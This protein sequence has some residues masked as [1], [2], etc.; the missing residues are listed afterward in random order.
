MGL[1]LHGCFFVFSLR[2]ALTLRRHS[3]T[4]TD[5]AATST[6]AS[7]I[8]Q[9]TVVN[10]V[11]GNTRQQTPLE[12]VLVRNSWRLLTFPQ[13]QG[14]WTLAHSLFGE[15]LAPRRKNVQVFLC[16]P[17]ATWNDVGLHL[18]WRWRCACGAL[19]VRCGAVCLRCAVLRCVALCCLM[20]CRL[21][22]VV[23]LLVR[24][25]VLDC[26]RC[27]ADI[28]KNA[29]EVGRKCCVEKNKISRQWLFH[30]TKRYLQSYINYPA[31]DLSPLWDLLIQSNYV[32][33]KYSGYGCY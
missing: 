26:H 19:V 17:R 4:L 15:F 13:Y 23:L 7:A 29:T 9:N 1:F 16:K 31:G 6:T 22:S 21:V 25:C 8:A 14:A 28:M 24:S 30:K 3:P 18:R 20:S 2:V 10:V 11:D 33:K 27:V 5:M 32:R 12:K